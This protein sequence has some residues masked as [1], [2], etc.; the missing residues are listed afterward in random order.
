M[1]RRLLIA[2]H[3]L[4]ALDLCA[5]LLAPCR[6]KDLELECRQARDAK[7]SAEQQAAASDARVDM[8]SKAVQKAESRA[9]LL[10]QRAQ[11][12]SNAQVPLQCP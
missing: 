8:L 10:E 3:P 9:T 12:S 2:D 6:V 4:V 1:R 7:T 11:T 5:M